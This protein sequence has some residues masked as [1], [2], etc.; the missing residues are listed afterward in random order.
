MTSSQLAPVAVR[1][2][3]GDRA[4]P[5]SPRRGCRPATRPG[6]ARSSSARRGRSPA[7]G[8]RGRGPPS[9]PITGSPAGSPS[10]MATRAL[11]WDSPAVVNRKSRVP[12]SSAPSLASK[13]AR[14]GSGSQLLHAAA[15]RQFVAPRVVVDDAR[16]D[17]DDQVR[18]AS[19][20]RDEKEK[21]VP[22]SGRRAQHRDARAGLV[23]FGDRQAAD[24][25]RLAVVDEELVVGLLL[26]EDEPEVRGRPAARTADRSVRRA[27][28]I[29]PVVGDVRRD[30]EPDAGLA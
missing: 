24:D 5:A 22:R 11:P 6:P 19:L 15:V 8:A 25:G 10:T 9:P 14:R 18:G 17:Q 20:R 28:R 3:H 12:V 4:S 2:Q 29:W 7:S 13:R 16:R 21:S 1:D 23:D 26:G 27:I 30:D